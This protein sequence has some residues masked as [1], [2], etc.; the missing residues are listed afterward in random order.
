[1]HVSGVLVCVGF[2]ASL[3]LC[4]CV[5]VCARCVEVSVRACARARASACVRVRVRARVRVC[6]FVCVRARECA[7]MCLLCGGG[8]TAAYQA[9][10]ATIHYGPERSVLQRRDA[11]PDL[12]LDRRLR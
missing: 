10:R 12:A 4:V 11:L 2:G 3:R 7:P 6:A 1:M 5:C 9:K 8:S